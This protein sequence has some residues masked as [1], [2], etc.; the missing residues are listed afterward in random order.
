MPD[1]L[2]QHCPLATRRRR[3]TNP[4]WSTATGS[5][6]LPTWSM[7]MG[8]VRR[9]RTMEARSHSRPSICTWRCQPNGAMRSVRTDRWCHAYGPPPSMKAR[10]PL[11]PFLSSAAISSSE[12]SRLMTTTPRAQSPSSSIAAK[13]SCCRP[14]RALTEPRRLVTA[15]VAASAPGSEPDWL[16]GSQTV[17]ERNLDRHR[18]ACGSR[19]RQAAFRKLRSQVASKSRSRRN[20]ARKPPVEVGTRKKFWRK[21]GGCLAIR[22]DE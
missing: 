20:A 13:R 7:T 3:A 6:N 5:K 9:L 18:H 17:Q 16:Q 14:R 12:A 11:T 15:P 22:S 2:T 19:T 4:A 1:S 8:T 10:T 21:I